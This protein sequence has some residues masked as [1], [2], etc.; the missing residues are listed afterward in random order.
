VTD[1]SWNPCELVHELYVLRCCLSQHGR[2][3]DIEFA[4]VSEAKQCI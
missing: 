4:S 1:S 2:C 3:L